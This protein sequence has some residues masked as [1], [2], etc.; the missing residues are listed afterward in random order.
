MPAIIDEATR[1]TVIQLW[2]SSL[3][4]WAISKKMDICAG[5]IANTTPGAGNRAQT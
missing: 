5:S 4:N 3:S 1:N 2:L